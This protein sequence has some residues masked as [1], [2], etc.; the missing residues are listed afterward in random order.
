MPKQ[1]SFQFYPGD[2]LRDPVSSC[3]LAA[4]GLWLRIMLAMHDSE[5]Y[6]YLQQDGAPIP[7]ERLCRIVGSSAEELGVLLQELEAAGV[8]SRTSRGVIFSRRMVRDF[9]KKADDRARQLKHRKGEKPLNDNKTKAP[10]HAP[11]THYVT[12][13]SQPSSSSSS[14]SED[15]TPLPPSSGLRPQEGGGPDERKPA[16]G[17][18]RKIARAALCD[19]LT[20]KA[21]GNL[22]SPPPQLVGR[23]LQA[24]GGETIASYERV[25]DCVIELHGVSS[26]V[27]SGWGWYSSA[28][29]PMLGDSPEARQ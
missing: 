6:G 28:L 23:L 3:S 24:A 18:E 21:R 16:F 11:V 19:Y 5:R 9:A 26:S 4:Q 27:P 10:C 1:P 13:L 25:R 29:M 12:D 7:Q 17:D 2:W 14:S 15:N 8:P 22:G 20:E